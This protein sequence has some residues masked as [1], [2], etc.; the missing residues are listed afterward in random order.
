MVDGAIA[1]LI[2]L[3]LTGLDGQ[4]ILVNPDHIVSLRNPRGGFDE[5][6]NC[7]I[8]TTDGKF[9]TVVESCDHVNK[10]RK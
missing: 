10:M 3:Q 7:L 4:I 8:N 2:W 9:I 5:D 1:A 6:V